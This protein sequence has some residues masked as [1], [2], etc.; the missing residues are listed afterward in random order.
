MS[1]S[2]WYKSFNTKFDISESIRVMRQ[3]KVLFEYVAQEARSLAFNEY[4]K[5]QKTSVLI[6]ATEIYL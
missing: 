5:E 1:N 6:Y 4:R 2:Q 3:L